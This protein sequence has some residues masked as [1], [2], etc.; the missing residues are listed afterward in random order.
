[1]GFNLAFRVLLAA[2]LGWSLSGEARERPNFILIIGDDISQEDFGCYGHPHIRTP[3]IDRMALG[4][5]RFDNAYLTASSCSPSRASIITARYPHNNGAAAELHRRLPDHLALFPELL[6]RAMD[7]WQKETGDS[8]PTDATPEWVEFMGD[9]LLGLKDYGKYGT[10]PGG[11]LGAERI[12]APG[13][14]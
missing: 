7:R 4:G 6:R 13:P 8:L 9:R 5:M 1:M 12:N 3:H 11:D 10:P 2:V 14:R